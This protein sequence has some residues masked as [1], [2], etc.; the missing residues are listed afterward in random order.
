MST[1]KGAALVF[2]DFAHAYDYISQDYILRVLEALDTPP[3]LL[4]LIQMMMNSQSGRVIVNNDLSPLFPV[5]NGGKQ[6]DPLFPLIYI[7]ALEG[8]YALMDHDSSYKGVKIPNSDTYLTYLGYADDTATAVGSNADAVALTQIFGTFERASGNQIKQA[9]S[10]VIWL[11]DWI[12]KTTLIYGIP[13][14]PEG[15]TERYLGL[16]VGHHLHLIDQ[17]TSTLNKLSSMFTFWQKFG[18]SIFGR[19]LL[20]NSRMLSQAWFKGS[21]VGTTCKQVKA[22]IAPPNLFFRKSKKNNT[23]SAQTRSLPL[24]CGG[25]AQVQFEKQLLL[26]RVKWVVSSTSGD[27]TPWQLYWNENLRILK[28]HL[29]TETDLRVYSGN[30]NKLQATVKN[31]DFPFMLAA[32]KAWHKLEFKVDPESFDTWSAQPILTNKYVLNDT[33]GEPNPATKGMAKV[34]KHLVTLNI[35]LFWEEQVPEPSD[36]FDLEKPDTW[37]FYPRGPDDL[38]KH[39]GLDFSPEI[40]GKIFECIPSRSMSIMAPGPAPPSK[41]WAAI[42]LYGQHVCTSCGNTYSQ[43][44]EGDTPFSEFPPDWPCP[45]AD[46]KKTK[47]KLYP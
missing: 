12:N 47:K 15:R 20:I 36:P 34:A 8:L 32:Y 22:L 26:L 37:R 16:Q 35:G 30:L 11:G 9:K 42:E 4:N 10:F 41:G 27:T 14:L 46:C 44:E 6:G 1:K 13:P 43:S 23:V 28:A 31:K 33:T 29:C 18:L 17:W 39:T 45:G 40:W 25:L 19:T 5:D 38:N 2:I 3:S 24:R 7:A 21:V